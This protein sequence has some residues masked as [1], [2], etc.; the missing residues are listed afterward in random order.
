MKNSAIKN[1]SKVI[2]VLGL[3]SAIGPFSIDM[4]LPGFQAIADDL[5]TT[6]QHIQLSLTSYFIGVAF[7]QLIYGPLLDRFGR[8]TPLMIGLAIY[9]LASI[10]CAVSYSADQLILY[11]FIQALGSCSGMVASRAIVRDLF[12]P[13]ETAK[14]FSMLML[15]LGVSPIL[16][17][18][19]GG[20]VVSAFGWH[21]VFVVLALIG[22]A[23][24]LSVIF[25]LPESKKPN[26]NLSLRP[27]PILSNYWT[28][29]KTPEFLINA[30]AG[31]IAGSGMYAYL[32]GSSYVMMG[33]FGINER[34]YGWIF[35]IIASALISASQVNT[36]L[37]KRIPSV[38]I[39]R[40]ALLFQSIIGAALFSLSSMQM[41]DLYG[42]VVLIFLFLACQGFAFP[43]TSAA[44]L[45]PFH[46]LAG[47]ASALMGSIQLGIGSVISASISL[48]H[49]GT[50][51]PMTG[52]M[53]LCAISSAIILWGTRN[54]SFRQ[55]N[56]DI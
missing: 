4:Y 26:K 3:L 53:C 37:I 16:A 39:A 47:S 54:K 1:K 5:G 21:G 28:V 25:I 56:R 52:L 48:L 22:L 49:D 6:V 32:S 14:I 55:D 17:P 42:M 10:A 12:P 30:F 31:G 35:A 50:A 8:K 44:A 41:I 20:Y 27:A 18:T 51:K 24:A 45:N 23:I 46:R 29:F 13:A 43:N 19:V 36:L 33:L 7:G 15:V 38:Q 9:V 40:V 11:R 2:F 34:Q